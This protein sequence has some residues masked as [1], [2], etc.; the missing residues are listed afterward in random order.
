MMKLHFFISLHFRWKQ[1]VVMM[2]FSAVVSKSSES[3]HRRCSI[4]EMFFKFFA[5]FTGKHLCQSLFFNKVAVL[6]PAVSM[7]FHYPISHIY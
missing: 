6:G 7:L 2:K 3:S 4:K 1:G 5:K